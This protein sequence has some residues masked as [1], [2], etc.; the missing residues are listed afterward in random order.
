MGLCLAFSC[1]APVE[2]FLDIKNGTTVPV[3]LPVVN[4]FPCFT[5]GIEQPDPPLLTN[6]RYRCC[7][8]TVLAQ[9]DQFP[10]YPGGC[11]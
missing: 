3:M 8:S 5:M 10:P 6:S 2:L 11:P 9:I 1:F 7:C 4:Q